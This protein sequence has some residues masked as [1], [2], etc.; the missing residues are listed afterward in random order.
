ML[1]GRNDIA[2]GLEKSRRTVL[3]TVGDNCA[4]KIG[5]HA[6]SWIVPGWELITLVGTPL[7]VVEDG[8]ETIEEEDHPSIPP[9]CLQVLFK[10]N[11]HS[12]IF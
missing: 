11:C 5:T 4:C 1:T 3:K 10:T 12:K 6:D 7:E 9:R 8:A 2:M